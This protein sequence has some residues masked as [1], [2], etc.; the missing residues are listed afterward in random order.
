METLI[1]VPTK[2]LVRQTKDK[3]NKFAPSLEVGT[4]YS[5]THDITKPITITTY[6]SLVRNIAN[7]T[8]NPGLYKLLVLDEV[9]RSLSGK[10]I[11]AVSK[12]TSSIRLGFTATPV[13]SEE[14]NVANLLNTEIHKMNVREA[15]EA[16]LLSPFSVIV[17]ETE[18]DLEEVSIKSN[19]DYNE[20]E[21]AEAINVAGRN[22]AAIDL[23]KKLFQGQTTIAYCVSVKHA[24]D[25]A[26]LFVGNGV[27]ADFITGYQSKQEQGAILK[28]FHDGEIKVLCNAD[29]LIEGFDEPKTSVCLNLRPTHSKVVAQQRG[30]RV[31]RLDEDNPNKHAFIVDFLDKTEDPRKQPVL[32]AEVAEAAYI[33]KKRVDVDVTAPTI[34]R[35]LGGGGIMDDKSIEISGLKIIVNP[36]EVMRITKEKQE[37]QYSVAPTEWMTIN[38]LARVLAT[39]FTSIRL[40]T[41]KFRKNHPE[42]FAYMLH[43]QSHHLLEFLSPESVGEIK[44]SIIEKREGRA[45]RNYRSIREQME[46]LLQN[47]REYEGNAPSG[48]MSRKDLAKTYHISKTRVMRAIVDNV[49]KDPQWVAYYKRSNNTT[50]YFSPEFIKNVFL[51]T[52]DPVP[53]GWKSLYD[54]RLY[55]KKGREEIIAALVGLNELYPNQM[56]EY[57]N[58]RRQIFTYYSPEI[59]Q[60]LIEK[61]SNQ[62]TD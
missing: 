6:A 44:K 9:H 35:G 14:R 18:V 15:V 7:G 41:Q 8:L 11:K 5:D 12:F 29:I 24:Q 43:P 32:F 25:L 40:V 19:G 53:E 60:K 57:T 16:D 26:N 52:K 13:Y 22:Q 37:R 3:L 38:A 33:A 59:I 34:H 2:I 48:W 28:K 27:E 36:Q 39:D 21:L 58:N 61:F 17:A 54:I 20:E 50:L 55:L 10:R 51:A 42:W 31:L 30:G 46:G 56:G 1:V 23:Y 49:S 45:K 4:L 47:T 62:A